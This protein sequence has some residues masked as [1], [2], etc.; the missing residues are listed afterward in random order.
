MGN[1]G[2]IDIHKV[3]I[4]YHLWHIDDIILGEVQLTSSVSLKNTF[5]KNSSVSQCI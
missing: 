1:T 2:S 4:T 5:L 3:G